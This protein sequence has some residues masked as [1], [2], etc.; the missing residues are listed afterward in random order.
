M[1]GN[2]LKVSDALLSL[3]F[4][5]AAD[6]ALCKEVLALGGSSTYRGETAGGWRAR[7]GNVVLDG[8]DLGVCVKM[9]NG[10]NLHTAS[11]YAERD[12][13]FVSVGDFRWRS[14]RH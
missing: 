10:T 2:L 13:C 4:L 8:K 12:W 3:T 11:G 6:P 1:R 5:G 14:W 7:E 9:V